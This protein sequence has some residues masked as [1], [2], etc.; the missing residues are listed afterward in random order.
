MLYEIHKKVISGQ[1]YGA[2]L[3]IQ[4]RYTAIFI[5]TNLLPKGWQG[6]QMGVFA[7]AHNPNK[8]YK[9]VKFY[10]SLLPALPGPVVN[11]P[12]WYKVFHKQMQSKRY[13]I[14]GYV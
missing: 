9:C 3:R 5:G 2:L 13:L 4:V 11:W 1:C 12:N 14:S 8:G 7:P 6:L 10:I